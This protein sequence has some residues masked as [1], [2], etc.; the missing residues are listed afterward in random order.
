MTLPLQHSRILGQSRI[1]H[2]MALPTLCCAKLK[3][4]AVGHHD[5]MTILCVTPPKQ[6]FVLLNQ[7]GASPFIA[8]PSR[9]PAPPR[10]TFA[11]RYSTTL[12]HTHAAPIFTQPCSASPSQHNATLYPYATVPNL[13][14]TP[15]GIVTPLHALALQ[16]TRA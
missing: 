14:S 7:A 2:R 12:C 4:D 13:A 1:V 8:L 15:L 3:P 10:G 5:T 6:Y 9:Y 11:P 16:C